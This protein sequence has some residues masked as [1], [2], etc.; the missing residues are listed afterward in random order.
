M[1][2]KNSTFKESAAEAET[3]PQTGVMLATGEIIME[4]NSSMNT[5][6]QKQHDDNVMILGESST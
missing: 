6:K 1:T 2:L 3:K 5:T 4:E